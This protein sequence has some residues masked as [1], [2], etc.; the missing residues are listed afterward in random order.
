MS[1]GFNTIAGILYED[2]ISGLMPRRT[3]EKKAS[4]IMKIIVVIL[5]VLC[6]GV[7][8]VIERLGTLM[9]MGYSLCASQNAA[10][11]TVFTLGLF[12]PSSNTIVSE[13][14]VK[15]WRRL[16]LNVRMFFPIT[17]SH[18]W[19]DFQHALYGLGGCWSSVGHD[20]STPCISR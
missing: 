15:N 16:T 2:F 12:F 8:Y 3:T 13:L 17:G 6:V 5:G 14:F 1:A 18:L 20:K 7:V 11:F 9:D 10:L 19:N 4:S